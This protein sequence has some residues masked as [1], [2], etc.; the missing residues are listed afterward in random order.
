M[1]LE[2][3]TKLAHYD[4]V[5]P[6]GAGGM[7]AVYRARDTKLDRDVAIKVLPEEL[8]RDPERLARFE[9]EAKLLASLNHPGIATLHGFEKV[10]QI[11]FLVMELV[12]GETLADRIA[13][14]GAMPLDETIEI[15]HQIA[16]A[17]EAAHEKGIVHRDLKPANIMITPEGRVKVLD[18]GL[19]KALV[20]EEELAADTSQSPTL[21]KGTAL[22]VIMGTASY[23]S[24]EQARGKRVDRRADV[25]AF[26]CCLYEALTG[27]KVFEG[28]TVTDTL[29]AVVKNEPDWERLSGDTP[30]WLRRL[31]E[32]S[33][34]KDARRRLRDIG[35]ARLELEEQAGETETISPARAS[36]VPWAM[37]ALLAVLAIWLAGDRYETQDAPVR[38]E[39]QTSEGHQFNGGPDKQV[40][41]SPN[42][43]KIVYSGGG[44]IYVH[45]LNAFAPVVLVDGGNPSDP[46]FSP[47]GNWIGFIAD[48][49]IQRVPIEGGV[50]IPICEATASPG[51]FWATDDTI[52]FADG[53][54]GRLLRVDAGGGEPQPLTRLG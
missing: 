1:S 27:K 17:L 54:S 41:F 21:T 5:E 46:F 51:V 29:A 18:F 28:E 45:S 44:R 12:E 19:A 31:L 49:R 48:G 9:R 22:G 3:G 38:F 40:A 25:W 47:N 53:R 16:E 37:V 42:G 33:L 2:P 7:G 30:L 43:T 23:M 15:F 10:D 32:R 4:V 36:F 14:G 20:P 24:P 6:I 11:V 52:I 50:P 35:D 26:G 39:I 13:T 8:S 34:R